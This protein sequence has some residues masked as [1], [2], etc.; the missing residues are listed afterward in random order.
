MATDDGERQSGRLRRQA[1]QLRWGVRVWGELTRVVEDGRSDMVSARGLRV[2]GLVKLLLAAVVLAARHAGA[3]ARAEC[4]ARAAHDAN[5][6]TILERGGGRV[7]LA[8]HL[9]VAARE[10]RRVLDREL[11]LCADKSVVRK[12]FVVRTYEGILDLVDR[13]L[14][15][16]GRERDS[17]L[18]MQRR[19]DVGGVV[20]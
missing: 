15:P 18:V 9:C 4:G 2:G 7:G 16:L 5:L 8:Q 20:D 19:W 13:L 1:E 6:A 10:R 14:E 3:A 12:L 11:Q 17:Q